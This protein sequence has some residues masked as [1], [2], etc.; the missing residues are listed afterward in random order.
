MLSKPKYKICKRLGNGIYE[1]CQTEKFALSEARAKKTYKRRRN[2]SDYGRQLLE[3]QKVRF[4]Y[5][6]SEK[7][8]RNYVLSANT[9]K[10]PTTELF[11][12][13]ETRLDNVVYRL[14]LAATRRAARQMVSHGHIVVNDKKMT[15]PSYSAKKGDAIAVREG[16][17]D[18]PL[19]II[20]KESITSHTAPKWLTLDAKKLSASI[21]APPEFVISD[22]IFDF[23]SV[24]EF[25][26]R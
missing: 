18:K 11:Q 25:Y 23:P 13:L 9:A 3:K 6:I 20:R 8:L 1:K 22:V 7:Q 26:S 4:A 17:M 16:S 19:F 14:G 24:F 2:V 10:E 5:G 12:E 21:K 15:V